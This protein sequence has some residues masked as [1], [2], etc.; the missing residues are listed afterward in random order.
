MTLLLLLKQ[1]LTCYHSGGGETICPPPRWQFDLRQNYIHLWTDPQ[2]AHGYAAGSQCAYSLEQLR[3]VCLGQPRDRQIDGS[4]YCL[5]PPMVGDIITAY[6]PKTE[7][8]IVHGYKS[9]AITAASKMIHLIFTI[10]H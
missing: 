5:M 1:C 3:S 9:T 7:S 4:W 10:Q 2:S 8:E 6:K